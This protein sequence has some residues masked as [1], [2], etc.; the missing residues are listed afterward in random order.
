MS[1]NA[2][3]PSPSLARGFPW[4]IILL[5][6]TC[7]IAL[8]LGMLL[9]WRAERDLIVRSKMAENRNLMT[10]FEEHVI[11]TLGSANLVLLQVA[12]DYKRAGA[13]LDTAHYLP[14]PALEKRPYAYLT[15]VDAGGRVRVQSRPKNDIQTGYDREAFAYLRDH[16]GAELF[17]GKPH[18]IAGTD[19]WMFALSRRID[20]HGGFS[21]MVSLAIDTKNFAAFFADLN[22]GP[23]AV[24]SLIGRDGVVRAR[25]LGG[26]FDA[27]ADVRRSALFAQQLPAAREGTFIGASPSDGI[28][29]IFAYCALTEY[30]LIV[31]VGS[32]HPA[33]LGEH[34]ERWVKYFGVGAGFSAIV[35]TFL[36]LAMQQSVRRAKATRELT[37]NEI[38][39][40]ESE[41]RFKAFMDHS[42]ASAFM[43]DAEGRYVYANRTWEKIF[44]RDWRAKTNAE[45]WPAEYAEAFDAT[46]RDALQNGES[47]FIQTLRDKQGRAKDLW[48]MKF[49][50]VDAAGNRFVGGV[51]LDVTERNRA[52]EARATLQAA[53]DQQMEGLALLDSEGC[54]TYVNRAHA[55]I[56]GYAPDDLIGR[57]W[58]ILYEPVYAE[59]IER[60]YFP[61]LFAN[62]SWRGE[63]LGRKKNGESFYQEITLMLIELGHASQRDVRFIC[64]CRDISDAKLKQRELAESHIALTNAMP[65]ISR[66]DLNGCYLAVNDDYAKILGWTPE[67]LIGRDSTATIY[68]DD[69]P[70]IKEAWETML[71]TG[72]VEAEVRGVRRDGAVFYKHILM[73][74]MFG[75]DGTHI[76]HYCFM[77]DI[78]ARKQAEAKLRESEERYIRA[79]AAGRVGVWELDYQTGVYVSD[80]NLKAMF[81][82]RPDELG[83]DPHR[84]LAL[85]HPEDRAA[86]MAASDGVLSG[87]S[88]RYACELRMIC[89]DG[90]IRWTDVRGDAERDSQ[91][92]VRRLSGTTVDVTARKHAEEAVR[93]GEQGICRLYEITNDAQ[94][95]F[96]QRVRALLSFGREHFGMPNGALLKLVGEQLE[97]LCGDF[98]DRCFNEGMQVP[99]CSTY[100]QSLLKV[101]GALGFHH[102]GASEW[103]DHPGYA[104]LGYEAYIGTKVSV[105]NEIFGT[106]CYL[107]RSP[108][109]V[110]FSAAEM[111]Y[112]ELMA[113]WI[114][115]ELGR[116]RSEEALRLSEKRFHAL[117]DDV[118]SMYF[119]VDRG[120]IVRSVNRFGATQLGYQP[121][122]LIGASV[123][124]VFAAEDRDSVTDKLAR[125]FQCK[126]SGSEWEFRK[127]RK[128]GSLIWVHEWV[129]IVDDQSGAPVALIACEDIT[130]RKQAEQALQTSEQSIRRLY[131]ITNA[132]GLSFG[133]RLGE[134]LKLGCQRFAMPNGAVTRRDGDDLEIVYAHAPGG[135]LCA[136]FR[137]PLASAYCQSVM[138][139]DDPLC[140]ENIARS[141]WRDHPGYRTM[142][143]QAY[144]GTKL[145][146][147]GEIYGTLC[148]LGAA[149]RPDPIS[150]ADKDFLKLMAVW[151]SGE[152]ARDQAV[153]DLRSAHAELEHRVV[154]RT[155]ALSRS[156]QLTQELADSRVKL[157]ALVTELSRAEERERRRLAV[158][159]HDYLAQSLALGKIAVGRADQMIKGPTISLGAKDAL[160]EARQALDSAISYTRTLIAELS[161][162]VLYDLGLL[163][164][165][166]WL[167]DQMK[168]HNLAVEVIG[169]SQELN[170]KEEQAVFLFQCVR[171]L[172]WNVIK[173]AETNRA[174][175][176]YNFA[177]GFIELSVEDF[178]KGISLDVSALHN[179]GRAGERFGLFSI[180]ERLEQQG[181]CFHIESNL[182]RGTRVTLRMPSEATLT[183][184]PPAVARALAQTSPD[185]VIRIALVDDHQ[186]VRQGLRRVLE[187]HGELAVVGEAGDGLEAVDMAA[188]VHPDVVIMDINL[189]KMSGLE[190]THRIVQGA[191]ATIV[192]GLSFGTD[193]YIEAAMKVAG[194][195]ACVTKERA[196]EDIYQAIVRSVAERQRESVQ[197]L[198]A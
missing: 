34:R 128:D 5:C 20:T 44:G 65:G 133:A 7:L 61:I 71:H 122:E 173:H 50:V 103:R 175:V 126:D 75:A 159:L 99:L 15:I 85:V 187:E 167:A 39:L 88:E 165:L 109:G 138:S 179:L 119:S 157:R 156:N 17:I 4:G 22:L 185:R 63:L 182:G 183:V 135:V 130:D 171:E 49:P 25:Q 189:P 147:N 118:P 40:R 190:A 144:M 100:C 57:S 154:E 178:G 140:F 21:G 59:T 92:R 105:D 27:G 184:S 124:K 117:Y 176:F 180:R 51:A 132:T 48:I 129:R 113:A 78:T 143:M 174:R 112:L 181:G 141:A 68:P 52:E 160:L 66:V 97:I 169:L 164:A 67:E 70:V 43:K 79:T 123:L 64:S 9:Q 36:A 139:S 101:D 102:I 89:K 116:Q 96:E 168:H 127:K 31:V 152:L 86:A 121:E 172:L 90:S 12:N 29:K 54:F 6:V 186:M 153:K 55:E 142:G 163:A 193:P 148:F 95:S 16:G 134:L 84:W 60:D 195:V 45:L 115:K 188:K 198:Q 26:R 162:M 74:K 80:D 18:K 33:L 72:K 62:G 196:V 136:G 47:S 146:V 23:N 8:W 53:I 30:P 155:E 69:Q 13:S 192:I 120:G 58:K 107:D 19:R 93:A 131:E 83:S 170:L 73:V 106:L 81:G 145:V 14:G 194:A 197:P 41:K 35:L 98:S 42:P 56:Y 158:E 37:L 149:P 32:S 177:D 76:G 46:D 77:R 10:I 91:G 111:N 24:V 87:A 166:R 108:R 161:P 110:P 3:K 28:D 114:G 94:L 38:S 150:D 151:V 125:A 2:V 11:R 104:A 1:V 82:Y 137:L 191:P